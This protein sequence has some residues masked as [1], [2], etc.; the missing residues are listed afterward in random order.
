MTEQDEVDTVLSPAL[1]GLGTAQTGAVSATE[2]QAPLVASAIVEWFNLHETDFT[3]MSNTINN[4]LTNTVYA[5]DCYLAQ[6]E[7]AA[8]EYQRQAV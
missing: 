2:T 6:D 8:L 7:E 1:E 5:V 3:S 4:V